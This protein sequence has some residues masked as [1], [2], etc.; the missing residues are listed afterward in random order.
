MTKENYSSPWIDVNKDMPYNHEE[1]TIDS[2][3]LLYDYGNTYS[4]FCI[5]DNSFC[6][7]D[8]MVKDENGNW[9]WESGYNITYWMPIPKFPVYKF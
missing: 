2:P 1:L 9:N 6:I 7:V 3:G 4:V 8:I 5:V